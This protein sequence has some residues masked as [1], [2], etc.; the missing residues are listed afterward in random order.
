MTQQ[1]HMQ[2]I[3]TTA[4]RIFIRTIRTQKKKKSNIDW[5]RRKHWEGFDSKKYWGRECFCKNIFYLKLLG[6]KFDFV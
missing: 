4:I 6:P 2:Y 1:Q 5:V 3:R